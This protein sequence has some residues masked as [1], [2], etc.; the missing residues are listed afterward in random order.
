MMRRALKQLLCLLAIATPAFAQTPIDPAFSYQ[1]ELTQGGALFTGDVDLRFRLYDA[2]TGGAQIGPTL[3][4][5]NFTITDGRFSVDLDFGM[6]SFNADARY[7]EIDIRSPGGS[8]AYTTLTPRKAISPAPVALFAL[9]GN[10]G[11]AGPQGPQGP[12]GPQGATG[13]TGPQGP[14]GPQGVAGPQGPQGSQ[15]AMGLPG[16]TGPQGPAGPQ[17]PSGIVMATFQSGFTSVPT[18]TRTLNPSSKVTL[19]LVAGQ[20]VMIVGT[21]TLG[22]TN[23]S[24]ADNLRLWPCYQISGATTNTTIGSGSYNLQAAPNTRQTY[25]TTGV[26]TVPSTDLYDIGVCTQVPGATNNWDLSE[27]GYVSVIVFDE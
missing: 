18:S 24:G 13:A 16:A 5:I 22:T 21:I 9:D 10:Q 23:P 12:A 20:K 26:F 1:G 15:G 14:A 27:F 8:G 17:G 25:S 7:L 2:S 4:L 11:P 3:A 6:G 19:P